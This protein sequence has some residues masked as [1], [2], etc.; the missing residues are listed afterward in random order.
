MPVSG[1]RGPGGDSPGPET[2]L[3]SIGPALVPS[4][5]D[6]NFC[7]QAHDIVDLQWATLKIGADLTLTLAATLSCLP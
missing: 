6:A 4:C 1:V 3:C 2:G 5:W 7:A